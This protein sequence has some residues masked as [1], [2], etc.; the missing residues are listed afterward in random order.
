MLLYTEYYLLVH[1]VSFIGKTKTMKEKV[2]R[3]PHDLLPNSSSI[4]FFSLFMKSKR[5]V[6]FVT[7][8]S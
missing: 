7:F 6:F 3:N 8:F 2:T 5:P 4:N 1:S